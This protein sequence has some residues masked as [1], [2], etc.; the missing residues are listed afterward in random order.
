MGGL[1]KASFRI[2]GG[3]HWVNYRLMQRSVEVGIRP[4]RNDWLV[5][6]NS[7]IM[8]RRKRNWSKVS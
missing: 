1:I 6:Q 2:R 4:H 3:P 5:A 8:K 7:R